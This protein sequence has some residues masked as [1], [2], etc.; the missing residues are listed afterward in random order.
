MKTK[1]IN[2]LKTLKMKTLIK[3]RLIIFTLALFCSLGFELK[4]QCFTIVNNLGCQVDGTLDIF[5]FVNP[6]SGFCNPTACAGNIP[7][8]AGPNGGTYPANCGQCAP[9]C[10]V[11]VTVTF[12]NTTP[13]T[14]TTADF[15]TT[16][17]VPLMGLAGQCSGVTSASIVYD[18]TTN[19]FIIN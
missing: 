1:T 4:S 6:P 10:N 16:T 18:P 5:T 14:A 3:M 2:S 11:V 13:I 15:S 19:S 12:L 8:S 9:V 17:P 7:W